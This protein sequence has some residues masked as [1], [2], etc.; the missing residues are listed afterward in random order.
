[1]AGDKWIK[2][3][4]L[5]GTILGLVMVLFAIFFTPDFVQNNLSADGILESNTI[6]KIN[7]VRVAVSI[8]GLLVLVFIF[9]VLNKPYWFSE[10]DIA[11]IYL[12]MSICIFSTITVTLGLPETISSARKLHSQIEK[13]DEHTL[14]SKFHAWYRRQ[15]MIWEFI[16]ENVPDDAPLLIDAHKDNC[17]PWFI[18]YYLAPRP[19]FLYSDNFDAELQKAERKYYLLT[20]RW[21]EQSRY[22]EWSIR[23]RPLDNVII[24][25]RDTSK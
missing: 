18:A 25:R 21:H 10:H 1:M 20:M 8:S 24:Q 14:R 11:N 4:P 9:L 17:P 3:G 16:R 22:L 6:A 15:H 5:F 19:V 23:E 2:I 13:Y 12:I 7:T